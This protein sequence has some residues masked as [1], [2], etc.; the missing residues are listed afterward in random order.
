MDVRTA[1][2]LAAVCGQTYVQYADGGPFVVPDGYTAIGEIWAGNAGPL[3]ERFGFVLESSDRVIVAFRGTRSTYDWVSDFIAE[4]VPYPWAADGGMSHQ[5]FTD[6][7]ATCRDGLV[8]L[9]NTLP[10]RKTL[11]IA[12]HSLGGALATLA[13]PDL[14]RHGG[15]G[16]PVVYTFA[17]PRV[18]NSRYVS[19]YNRTIQLSARIYNTYDIVPHLPPFLY[20]SPRTDKL[21]EYL[22]VKSGYELSYDTGSLSGNHLLKGYFAAL[23]AKDPAFARSMCSRPEGLCPII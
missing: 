21:Y 19:M 5:G 15:M 13:A 22:H 4:Q 11:Y 9:L 2:F 7:Y 12:G 6:I 10:R 14:A 3:P 8:A 18:G 16:Q 17:A 1:L 23:A 20:K